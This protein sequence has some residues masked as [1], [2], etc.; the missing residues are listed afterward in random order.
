MC[1]VFLMAISYMLG[2]VR[3]CFNKCVIL[4]ACE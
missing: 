2:Y 1:L 4:H 3:T